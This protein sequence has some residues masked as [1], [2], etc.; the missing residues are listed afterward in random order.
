MKKQVAAILRRA[1]E[2]CKEVETWVRQT[3]IAGE[4]G[5]DGDADKVK[6]V[7]RSID[8]VDDE[9]MVGGYCSCRRPRRPRLLSRNSRYGQMVE[10]SQKG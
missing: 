6:D 5:V 7:V 9:Q 10:G 1:W 8:V 2:E 3:N 4:P